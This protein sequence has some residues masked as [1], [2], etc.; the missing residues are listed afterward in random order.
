MRS[1]LLSRR[2]L[3]LVASLA[4]LA[5]V[6]DRMP[7][8]LYAVTTETGMPHLEENLRYTTTHEKR[9]LSRDDLA[10]AF[11]ILTHPT[12][13]GCRLAHPTG[14][15]VTISYVLVCAGTQAASGRALWQLGDDR[16]RGTLSVKL[17]GKNMTFYQRLTAVPLGKCAR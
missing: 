4:G 2:W 10:V 14:D 9:C 12:L 17:G 16:V 11:P 7:P 13:Q 1:L 6:P 3:V 8:R 15:G 5:A